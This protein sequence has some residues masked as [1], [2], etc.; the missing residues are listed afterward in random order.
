[1]SFEFHLEMSTEVIRFANSLWRRLQHKI[2]KDWN[3]IEN[4]SMFNGN[5]KC[6]NKTYLLSSFTALIQ[7]YYEYWNKIQKKKNEEKFECH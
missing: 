3:S 2:G 7:Y 4:N 6:E 5:D 1:M